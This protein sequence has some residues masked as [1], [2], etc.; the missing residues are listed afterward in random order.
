M[1]KR[2]VVSL[3]FNIVETIIIYMVG[4]IFKVDTNVIITMMLVF[5]FTRLLIG[6]P[7]HYATWYRC[8]VFSLLTFSS[9]YALT[10]LHIFVVLLM[11]AFTGYISTGKADIDGMYMW[12]GK[13][14]KN[15]DVED[16]VKYHA[17]D[18]KLLQFEEKIKKQDNI[19]YL[20]YKY[21]YKDGKS[22]SE[23]S[24]LLGDMPT[25]D[26]SNKLDGIALTIRI[27]CGV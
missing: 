13:S 5:F 21:R 14:T 26:I 1:N 19:L 22:F 24:E 8:L 27:Y 2:F 3:I 11:T 15:K 18:D 23:I 4:L 25:C 7:K 9:V 20:I 6:S 12:K 17:L 16:Y 10:D